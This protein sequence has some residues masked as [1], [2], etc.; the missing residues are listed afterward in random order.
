MALAAAGC[1]YLP[2]QPKTAVTAPAALSPQCQQLY[3][4]SRYQDTQM[5]LRPT[6]VFA[7]AFSQDRQNMVCA[8]A[9]QSYLRTMTEG[10]RETA[11]ARC[12]EAR[13]IWVYNTKIPLGPCEV[14]AEGNVLTE[15]GRK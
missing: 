13:P 14:F 3:S 2:L 10:N 8:Y 12:E 4:E 6:P 11:L 1:S 15:A 9:A 7:V 5:G